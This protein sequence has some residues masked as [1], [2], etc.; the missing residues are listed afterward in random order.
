MGD[1]PHRASTGDVPHR[2]SEPQPG[3]ATLQRVRRYDAR[4]MEFSG[5]DWPVEAPPFSE[6]AFRALSHRLQYLALRGAARGAVALPAFARRG[7]VRAVARV[8]P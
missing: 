1:L 6:P 4:P 5:I 8:P 3:A 7:L 2:A